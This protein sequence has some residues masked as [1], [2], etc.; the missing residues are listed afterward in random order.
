MVQICL[1]MAENEIPKPVIQKL[2][3]KTPASGDREYELTIS[4][5]MSA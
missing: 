3:S 5:G 4:E 1:K 2:L